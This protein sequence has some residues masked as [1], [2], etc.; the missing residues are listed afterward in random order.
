MVG[1]ERGAERTAGV[2]GGRL[3]PDLL[4]LAVTQDLAIRNAVQRDTAGQAEIL[5][6]GLLGERRRQAQHDLLGDLLHRRRQV[7]LAL[8]HRLLRSPRR[9][10]EQLVE[11]RVGHGQAGTIIEVFLIDPKRPVRL[12]VDQMIHDGLGIFWLTIRC[13]A[14]DLVLAGVD[15]EPGVI[16]ERRV[17]QPERVREHDLLV[18]LEPVAAAHA[19]ARGRPLADP[20]DGQHR[21]RLERRGEERARRMALVMLGEQQAALDLFGVEAVGLGQLLELLAQQA[22]LEQLLLEPHR[23][24]HAERGEALGRERQIGLE[25]ALELEERLVVERDVIDFVEADAGLAQA[26]RDRAAGKAGIMLLAA[27][28]LLLRRGDDLAVLDQRRCAVVIEC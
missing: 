26:V 18:H 12:D 19:D 15:L 20:V 16:G 10:P 4:E 13:Q 22:L 21:G 27:E 1:G 9:L 23:H 14:H 8:P 3:D 11:L 28:A 2:A 7:H 17:Q 25:Q 24:R 6:A 5:G